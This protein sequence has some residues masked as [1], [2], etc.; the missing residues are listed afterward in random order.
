MTR[1]R[2]QEQCELGQRQLMATEYLDAINTLA[3]AEAAAWAD[4]DLSTLAQAVHAA[5]GSPKA[6]P[7]AM[8]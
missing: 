7:A 4:R 3:A 8:W 1:E 6:G 5:T 2:L